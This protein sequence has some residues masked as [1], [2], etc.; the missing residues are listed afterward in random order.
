MD[1]LIN[2]RF[3]YWNFNAVF[4]FSDIRLQGEYRVFII[5]SAQ[6]MLNFGFQVQLDFVQKHGKVTFHLLKFR[7]KYLHCV[8]F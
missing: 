4:E 6:N 2:K 8:L 5:L 3:A 7:Q 1:A